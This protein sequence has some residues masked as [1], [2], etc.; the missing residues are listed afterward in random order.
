MTGDA[1]G[2]S[3]GGGVGL[4]VRCVMGVILLAGSTAWGHGEVLAQPASQVDGLA[5]VSAGDTVWMMLASA[6]VLGMVVPG[7]AAFYGGQV[8][9]KNALATMMHSMSILC[10]VSVIWVLVGYTLSFG[11]DK[12]GVIGGLDWLVLKG[13]GSEPHAR[14]A[15]TVP[16]AGFMLFQLM[17]A[18]FSTALM[19]GALAERVRFGAMLLLIS[20]WCVFIYCPLA[21]WLWGGGWLARLGGRDFAGGAVALLSAGAAALAC[22]RVLGQRRGYRTEY[23]APH[24][25]ALTLVGCGLLWVGWLGLS[26][27]GARG[28]SPVAVGAL[29][30]THLAAA[31]AGLVWMVIEWHH[32]GKPTL[33]GVA[34]GAAAGLATITAGAGYVGPLSAVVSGA[35]GGLCCYGAIVVKGKTRYDDPLDVAGIYGI[36]GLVGV[37]MTGLLASKAINPA[38]PDGFFFGGSAQ[39]GAQVVTAGAVLLFSFVGTY[40]ILKLVDGMIG[41]RVSTEEEATGLDLSQHNERAYS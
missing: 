5:G 36:G 41:L 24:N 8:R 34:T 18:A 22:T 32:R 21:H 1:V 25:L 17:L 28:A 12:G 3:G 35:V 26:G 4:P 27:G 23:L 6:L 19:A 15:P 7:L 10:L 9:S 38:G 16:H 20:L 30:A 29:V 11:P 13:V 14:Y 33:L 39:L 2:T 40:M 31:S 37:V